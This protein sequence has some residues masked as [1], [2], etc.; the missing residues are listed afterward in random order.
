MK[1]GRAVFSD[2]AGMAL[3]GLFALA[4][5]R[6]RGGRLFSDR[7]ILWSLI[8][9]ALLASAAGQLGWGAAEVGRQPWIVYGLLR[10]SDAVSRCVPAGHMLASLLLFSLI[11]ALL[12]GVWLKILLEKLGRGPEEA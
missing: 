9:A 5:W 11:Y 10:T 12:A 6:L 4:A 2:V 8:P 1:A 7:L 3:A